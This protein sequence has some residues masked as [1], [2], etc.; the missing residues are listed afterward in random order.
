MFM[1]LLRELYVL[2]F[3]QNHQCRVGPVSLVV[4]KY[5]KHYSVAEQFKGVKQMLFSYFNIGVKNISHFQQFRLSCSNG[6]SIQR[7]IDVG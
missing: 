5:K 4:I 2:F 3:S 7:K 6:S 1:L